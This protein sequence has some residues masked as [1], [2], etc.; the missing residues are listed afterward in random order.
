MGFLSK[1]FAILVPFSARDQEDQE[2]KVANGRYRDFLK[3]A[4]RY[5]IAY[6]NDLDQIIAVLRGGYYA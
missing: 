2:V 4:F 1:I 5:W 6:E 3:E